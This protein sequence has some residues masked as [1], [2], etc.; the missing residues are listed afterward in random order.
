MSKK[1]RKT[2]ALRVEGLENR[3]LMAG[4]LGIQLVNGTLHISGSNAGDN[5]RVMQSG[6]NLAVIRGDAPPL[7]TFPLAAVSSLNIVANGGNDRVEVKANSKVFDTFFIDL[8]SGSNEIVDVK[9]GGARSATI[10]ARASLG[11]NVYLDGVFSG[12]ASVD[13]GTDLG[14]DFFQ[15][16]KSRFNRLDLKMGGGND[17][18]QLS[19]T[20]VNSASISMG[21]GDDTFHSFGSDV[22]GGIIDGG[23]AVRGNK[24]SG[25]RFGRGVTI[26]GF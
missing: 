17:F 15:T 5:I 1:N 19:Q 7:R 2:R 10:D 16:Q 4:D 25:A 6:N 8:G 13:Y 24:W 20:S 11:T 21:D 22:Q 9:I 26:R 23:T 3:E 14:G 18:C 12:L